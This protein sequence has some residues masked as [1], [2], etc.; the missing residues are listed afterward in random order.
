MKPIVIYLIL[1]LSLIVDA[2]AQ[3]MDSET[4]L[5]FEYQAMRVS[6]APV[7]DGHLEKCY[8]AEVRMGLY[9]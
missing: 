2:T 1:L 7:V 3:V 9:G 5:L 6:A 4:G 8:P